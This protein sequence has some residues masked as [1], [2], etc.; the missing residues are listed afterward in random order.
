MFFFCALLIAECLHL[1]VFNLH[2][3]MPIT[4][5]DRC[6]VHDHVHRSLIEVTEGAK[7]DDDLEGYDVSRVFLLAI[8]KNHRGISS[9]LLLQA[10]TL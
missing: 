5:S 6:V 7:V 3:N 10:A 2:F 4:R 9:Q 8:L 1:F